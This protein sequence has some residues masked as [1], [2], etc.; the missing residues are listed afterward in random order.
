MTEKIK[1]ENKN[2]KPKEEG[3]ITPPGSIPLEV[4]VDNTTL[5]SEHFSRQE[6][7]RKEKEALL[8]QQEIT[9]EELI[10]KIKEGKGQA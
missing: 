3:L 7:D 9:I 4:V 1:I 8:E 5:L 2:T 6:A 10:Q